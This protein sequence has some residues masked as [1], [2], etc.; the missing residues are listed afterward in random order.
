MIPQPH[1]PIAQKLIKKLFKQSEA[2]GKDI[3]IA[4]IND[5]ANKLFDAKRYH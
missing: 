2:K 3:Y 5:H 1:S 4:D